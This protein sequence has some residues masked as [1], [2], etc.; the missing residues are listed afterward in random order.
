MFCWWRRFWEWRMIIAHNRLIMRLDVIWTWAYTFRNYP[1]IRQ[2]EYW[3]GKLYQTKQ[4]IKRLRMWGLPDDQYEG[5]LRLWRRVY[6]VATT[7]YAD[8]IPESE[9][10]L[11][12]KDV[13]GKYYWDVTR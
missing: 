12:H 6:R 11:E 3:D 10:S 4:A 5:L 2:E 7:D 13:I 8:G 9:I 1:E